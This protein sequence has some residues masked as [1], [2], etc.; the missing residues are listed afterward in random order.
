MSCLSTVKARCFTWNLVEEQHKGICFHYMNFP[1]RLTGL[2]FFF[3]I[4]KFH[5]LQH[6]S[7]F[8]FCYSNC[9][10]DCVLCLDIEKRDKIIKPQQSVSIVLNQS[11]QMRM[12]GA[13]YCPLD[14]TWKLCPPNLNNMVVSR[15]P[16]QCQHQSTCQC[17][18]GN[19]RSPYL[20]DKDL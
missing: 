8:L 12:L 4:V 3:D 9:F 15:I 13:R 11:H 20:L 7:N 14:M 6:L 17:R 5:L 18:W 16:A 2:F 10:W 19:L 1:C